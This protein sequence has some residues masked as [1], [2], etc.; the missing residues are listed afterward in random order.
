[1]WTWLLKAP[2]RGA[3]RR[4]DFVGDPRAGVRA[5]VERAFGVRV[6]DW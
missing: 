4:A 3:A 1:M 5:L 2:R 6:F